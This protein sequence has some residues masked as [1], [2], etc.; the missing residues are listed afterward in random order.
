MEF[1][2]ITY[3]DEMITDQATLQRLPPDLKNFY[4][5]INGLV[6]YQ[7]GLHIRGCVKDPSWH[8]LRRV[9]S[10]DWALHR[11]FATLTEHDVPFAQD[12][13]GDQYF[14]R[15]GT[16]WR[17]YWDDGEVEDLELELYD[18]FDEVH[19]D[20]IDFLDLEPLVY[21]LEQGKTLSPGFLLR[22]D[23][24]LSIDAEHY[25]FMPV[26]IEDFLTDQVLPSL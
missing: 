20:P 14:W 22:S 18:F 4:R 26:S 24:P 12:C 2:G 7:G 1:R 11:K 8:S 9:W 13:L 3:K 16:I 5:E 19:L 25:E 23:P 6:A 21:Y 15:L 10:D 17:L